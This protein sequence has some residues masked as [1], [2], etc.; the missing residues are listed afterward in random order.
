MYSRF[1]ERRVREALGDTRVV[2]ICGARQSGKTTLAKQVSDQ[3][4]PFFTLDDLA[5]FKTA[6]TDPV[7]FVRE[8]DRAVIDEV[9]KVPELISAIKVA[10]DAHPAPGRFLL[11]GSANLMTVPHVSDS[12]AGRMET[13]HLMPLAQVEIQEKPSS[14]LK[15][16]F[17]GQAPS[18]RSATVGKALAEIVLAGGYP[19][20]LS[21][22]KWARRQSWHLSYIDSIIQRDIGS[23]A[24]IEQLNLMPKFLRILAEYSGQLV[25]YSK[26][27]AALGMNHVTTRKY[28]GVFENLFLVYALQPWHTNTLKRLIK[29]PKLHF[30][31]SGLLA[32]LKRIT[33]ESL[34]RDRSLLGPVLET[35]V[36]GELIKLVSWDDDRYEFWHFRD[37]GKNEVDIVM[38]NGHGQIVGIEVKA[39]A[40]V[41]QKDFSGLRHLAADCGD[42][43]A[44]GLVLY[45]H[46]Y[47]L[48]FGDRMYTAPIS[49]LWA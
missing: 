21:R 30:L 34:H 18:T 13:V 48:R 35:F 41:S 42:R 15:Q 43:F 47:T 5:T 19:E 3:A 33:P 44:L 10:V 11:T 29:T 2:M 38:E 26:L 25:N 37:K 49:T 17:S 22:L 40:T 45:D 14:F 16:V 8:L 39:A 24:Q 9:Q 12:L 36:L 20:A 7:N 28:V 23:L 4:I 46:E 31:D 6:A 27:G 1:I 32:S